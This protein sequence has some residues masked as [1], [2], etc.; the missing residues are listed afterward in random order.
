MSET[1]DPT[2]VEGYL[3]DIRGELHKRT[4][5]FESTTDG[6]WSTNDQTQKAQ[7]ASPP[8]IE[9]VEQGGDIEQDTGVTQTGG[10]GGDIGTDEV[11]FDVTIWTANKRDCR[12]LR[13]ELLRAIRA[14]MDGP[15]YETSTYTWV[16]DANTKLGR[17]MTLPIVLRF[18]IP[19]ELESGA[20]GSS[21]GDYALVE[22]QTF[23]ATVEETVP[24]I[25]TA[26]TP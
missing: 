7:H 22:L 25:N 9:W 14:V 11:S 18:P 24:V 1:R 21:P 5:L 8:R 10:T 13:N 12:R 19:R 23:T 15:G 17:K 2:D 4:G 26:P 20:D 16:P 6:K 3:E